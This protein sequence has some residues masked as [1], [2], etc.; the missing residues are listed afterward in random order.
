MR[1]TGLL[2][3]SLLLACNQAG[4]R[5]N[6]EPASGAAGAAPAAA[7]S[8][9][10]TAGPGD[11]VPAFEVEGLSL[12]GDSPTPVKIASRD[13]DLPAAYVFV[14]TKCG[15]TAKYMGRLKE[16]EK[17]HAGR[18]DFV[19]LYPNKTDPAPERKAFHRKHALQGPLV[20]DPGGRVATLLGRERTAEVVVVGKDDTIV[21]AGAI[22]DNKDEAKVTRKHLALA[23]EEHLAG[24][25]VSQPKT[26]GTA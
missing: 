26:I 21:Y 12:A 17:A 20:E 25:T 8:P 3:L 2:S 13:R 9:A 19:F 11:K 16:L 6:A 15:T 22:D 10:R 4:D 18:V 1:L 24:K 23:L 14:G 7:A 5:A